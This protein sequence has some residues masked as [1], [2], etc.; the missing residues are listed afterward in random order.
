MFCCMSA[1]PICNKKVSLYCRQKMN[2][3]REAI[4][5]NSQHERTDSWNL[6]IVRLLFIGSTQIVMLLYPAGMCQDTYILPYLPRSCL[7]IC[8]WPWTVQW[9]VVG[10]TAASKCEVLTMFH[11]PQSSR[12]LPLAWYNQNWK[13]IIVTPWTWGRS[14]CL[15]CWKIFIP[16]RSAREHFVNYVAAK[17]PRLRPAT[18]HRHV[19][20]CQDEQCHHHHHHH[21]HLLQH[22]LLPADTNVT[23]GTVR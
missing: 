1:A 6:C 2:V 15:K 8:K 23:V 22:K 3:A 5:L 17:A 20:W 19:P 11:C 10:H 14:E 16:W 18:W 21:H 4:V 12:V 7:R 9:N 13:K